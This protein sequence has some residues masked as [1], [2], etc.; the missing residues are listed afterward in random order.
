MS[1]LDGFEHFARKDESLAGLT[2][3]RF[4]ATAEFFAEPTNQDELAA[5]LKRFASEKKPVRIIGAGSNLLVRDAHVEG[6]VVQLSAPAFSSIDVQENRIVVGGG[7]RLSHFVA[8]AVGEGMSGPQH[9]VGL[10]GTIGGALYSDLEFPNVDI[11]TW[12]RSIKSLN[13]DGELVSHGGDGSPFSH[14]QS[15]LQGQIIVS[16]EMEFEKEASEG[17]TKQMQKL[18]I[19]RRAKRPPAD[20]SAAWIFKDHGG[21]S[22]AELIESAGLKGVSSGGVSL[23]DADPNFLVAEPGATSE[24]AMELIEHIATEVEQKLGVKLERAIQ[25]W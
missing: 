8:S 5:I 4:P 6:L 22:A 15:V 7:T 9:L 17:L 12:V 20:M 19:V 11:G 10:P 16:V 25:V 14:Y 24:Q 2:G 23:F 18:W 1:V 13:R 3:L 21:Q